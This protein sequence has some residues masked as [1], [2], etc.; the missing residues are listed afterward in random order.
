MSAISTIEHIPM[1]SFRVKLPDDFMYLSS[2]MINNSYATNAT[3]WGFGANEYLGRLPKFAIDNEKGVMLFSGS[4]SRW[5]I[6]RQFQKLKEWWN[7]EIV[8]LEYFPYS[9]PL[10]QDK[11]NF[12]TPGQ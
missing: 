12:Y 3:V 4:Y 8:T 9:H 10:A 1:K 6:V 5:W 7:P 2:V 11:R